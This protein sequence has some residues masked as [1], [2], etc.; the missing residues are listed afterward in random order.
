MGGGTESRSEVSTLYGRSRVGQSVLISPVVKARTV[1][2]LPTTI[3]R[4]TSRSLRP[5]AISVRPADVVCRACPLVWPHGKYMH[6]VG[7]ALDLI[8]RAPRGHPRKPKARRLSAFDSS[9]AIFDRVLGAPA[10]LKR[11][12]TGHGATAPRSAVVA[13]ATP[14]RSAA[15]ALASEETSFDGGPDC[16]QAN[17]SPR[18]IKQQ[19]ST[20][21]LIVSPLQVSQRTPCHAYEHRAR[22]VD[23]HPRSTPLCRS[24]PYA[25][26]WR[27]Q[28]VGKQRTHHCRHGRSAWVTRA[29]ETRHV[30]QWPHG[31]APLRTRGASDA[32]EAVVPMSPI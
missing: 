21:D 11:E 30:E 4:E 10:R 14:G 31:L 17:A 18:A 28:S 8:R 13:T 16:R 5:S 26:Q 32:L 3:P 12:V 6:F 25:R 22:D 9:M 20:S 1:A 24:S 23:E 7:V 29:R 27:G 15:P 19:H 2:K